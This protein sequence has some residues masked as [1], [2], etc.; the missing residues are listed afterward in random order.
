MLCLFLSTGYNKLLIQSLKNSMRVLHI[1]KT[2]FPDSYGGV[3]QVIYQLCSGLNSLNIENRVITLS[4]DPVPAV[5]Q[6]PEA[7]VY[8]FKKNIEIASCGFSFDL[9]RHF[10]EHV[11]WADVV[12]Y[13]F[14]WPFADLLHC[15]WNV[16]KPTLVTYQ[17]DIVKQ[18]NLLKLYRPLMERFLAKVDII[19]A[20]S[21]NYVESSPVL[22]KFLPKIKIIPIGL[23]PETYPPVDEARRD[24][25]HNELGEKFFLFVGVLRYYKGLHI[26]LDAIHM[27]TLQVV[28][29]GTG[30]EE[31]KLKAKAQQLGLKNVH[32]LGFLPDEDKVALLSLC[33]AVVF[34][35]HLR[36]EAFGVSLLEGAMFG[37]PLISCDTGTG[38]SYIN[39][40]QETGFVVPPNNPEVLREAMLALNSNPKLR[41]EM[42]ARAR[43]RFLALFTASKMVS[44]H[45]NIYIELC[46]KKFVQNN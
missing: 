19:V 2:Y 6:R 41:E 40:D 43:Q 7:Q 4:A 1:Y 45:Q 10:P 5:L 22:S 25:W 33:Q 23:N 17:S 44:E 14:P 3:E 38:S 12:H 37:K 16:K 11:A 20:T 13:H 8:R 24:H 28:I 34:P 26:L 9:M 31:I 36:S 21:P 18:K 27:T 29:V 30:P 42:G 15:V 35:S 39:I 46:A 32:F